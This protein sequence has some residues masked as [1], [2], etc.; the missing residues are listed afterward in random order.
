MDDARFV[1]EIS[2]LKY[3]VT[4]A[5]LESVLIPLVRNVI[6]IAYVP[7]SGK[8]HIPARGEHI[9]YQQTRI[10]RA[11][12]VCMCA[13]ARGMRE[14]LLGGTVT[15]RSVGRDVES[16]GRSCRRLYL[17]DSESEAEPRSASEPVILKRACSCPCFAPLTISFMKSAK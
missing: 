15:G 3:P 1:V 17:P 10:P 8:A 12:S 14:G 4:K 7:R 5:T 2:G 13:C 9:I 11:P 6:S 16:I